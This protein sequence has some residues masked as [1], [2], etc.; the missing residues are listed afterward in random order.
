MRAARGVALV[1]AV[2]VALGV[3][4]EPARG[5]ESCVPPVEPVYVGIALASIDAGGNW[6]GRWLGAHPLS[7]DGATYVLGVAAPSWADLQSALGSA[8]QQVHLIGDIP[9]VGD[10]TCAPE[11]LRRW[12]TPGPAADAGNMRWEGAAVPTTA[13]SVAC[14]AN[15]AGDA[16]LLLVPVERVR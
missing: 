6:F 11:T 5:A 15:A 9:Y 12:W 10:G 8:G 2:G 4:V 14:P 13:P 1:V 3:R 7:C 16:V